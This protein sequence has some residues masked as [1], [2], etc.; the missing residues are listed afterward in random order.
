MGLLD[1]ITLMKTQGKS[2]Q[3]IIGSLQEQGI[4]PKMISD[5]LS[6]AQIKEAVSKP[7]TEGMQESIMENTEYQEPYEREMQ[8]PQEIVSPIA[9]PAEYPQQA[10]YPMQYPQQSQEYS[11]QEYSQDYYPQEYYPQEGYAYG[12]ITDTGTLIEIAE[13]VFSDKIKKIQK[14]ADVLSEFKVLTETRLNTVEERLRRIET[15]ID[16]LQLS[17]LDKIGSYGTSIESVKKEMS[18]MQDSFSKV[19]N[20]VLDKTARKKR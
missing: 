3:E 7:L 6:Q 10:I 19:I 20:P 11:T 2:D 5:A 17:I 8:A 4:P 14:Q 1:Q 16:K 9:S 18:M 15:T 12:G 13:Q